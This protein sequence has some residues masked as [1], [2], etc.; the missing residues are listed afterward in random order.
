VIALALAIPFLFLH[1]KYQPG[2][3]VPLG[4]THLGIEASDVAILVVAIVALRDGLRAGFGRLRPALSLWIASALLLVWIF[5][6]TQSLT[7]AVTAA[8][9]AEYALLAI[10]LPLILRSFRQWEVVAGAVV[11]WSVAATFVALLQIFGWGILDAWAAGR[12]QPSFLGHSDFAALSAFALGIGLA[13]VLNARR[14][15]G[16]VGVA[17][18]VVGLMLAGATAGLIGTVAGVIG[19][20]ILLARRRRLELRDFAVTGGCVALVAAGVLA[21]RAGDFEHFLRFLHLKGRETQTSNIETYSHH[22]LL[23]YIGYRIWRDHPVAGAGWQ[24]S[25]EPAIVDPVLPAAHRRFPDLAPLAFPTREHEW[26]IQNAYIQGAAD[27]G[28]VGLVLLVAPFAISLLLAFRANAP[29]CTVATFAVL[30]AAGIWLGQGIVAG[31]P[32]DALTWLGFGLAATA[33]AQR[34]SGAA[35]GRWEP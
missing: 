3:R 22:T 10:S 5:V 24:A 23:A 32:L 1:V 12:R 34:R 25:N 19:L 13:A 15:I 16:W 31:I 6:R 28:I 11:A 20:L 18:G 9:F 33:A 30:A 2:V 27:L 35:Q 7:H 4:S 8:K 14:S 29:P 21:L 26:G 17:S